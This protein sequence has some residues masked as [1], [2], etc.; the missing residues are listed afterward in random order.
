M[1][2]EKSTSD[3]PLVYNMAKWTEQHERVYQRDR[4]KEIDRT[5]QDVFDLAT[6][7]TAKPKE[8]SGGRPM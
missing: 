5:T 8:G 1:P 6:R 2:F 3:R 7:E 4:I